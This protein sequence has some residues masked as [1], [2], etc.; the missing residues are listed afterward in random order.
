MQELND[1]LTAESPN[2]RLEDQMQVRFDR[3]E[4]DSFYS[5]FEPFDLTEFV[6][7]QLD[8]LD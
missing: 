6:L 1:E 2:E 7:D 8:E 3:D 5:K 4:L